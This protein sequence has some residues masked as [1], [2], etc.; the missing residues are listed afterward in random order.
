MSVKSLTCHLYFFHMLLF[1]ISFI[2]LLIQQ[3]MIS[4][5]WWSWVMMRSG[6]RLPW[7][8]QGIWY[9][10]PWRP[11]NKAEKVWDRWEDAEVSWELDTGR[12]QRVVISRAGSVWRHV[13]S[14]VPQGSMLGLISFNIFIN[15]LDERIVSTL[16]KYGWGFSQASAVWEELHFQLMIDLQLSGAELTGMN[17]QS[18]LCAFWFQQEFGECWFWKGLKL[19][20]HLCLSAYELVI[21]VSADGYCSGSFLVITYFRVIIVKRCRGFILLLQCFSLSVKLIPLSVLCQNPV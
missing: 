21:A 19:K 16:N 3:N 20:W 10:L 9:C 4:G 14:G 12:A 7:H 5:S 18:W 8:Q 17:A 15:D 13:T 2:T 6:C 1:C 11:H